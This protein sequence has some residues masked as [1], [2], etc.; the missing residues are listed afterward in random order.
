MKRRKRLSIRRHFGHAAEHAAVERERAENLGGGQTH[1]R[2][3]NPRYMKHGT[4]RRRFLNYG[5]AVVALMSVFH[6]RRRQG[7]A[8]RE[9]VFKR[10]TPHGIRAEYGKPYSCGRH[11]KGVT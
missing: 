9:T 3:E 6:G 1:R 5:A 7:R 10:E 4:R 8:G 11:M 2:A